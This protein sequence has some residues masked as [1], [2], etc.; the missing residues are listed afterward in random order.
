MY[1]VMI[2]LIAVGLTV[3]GALGAYVAAQKGREPVE[4]LVFGVLLGPLGVLVAGLMPTRDAQS[5]PHAPQPDEEVRD[6]LPTAGM[7]IPE[8]PSEGVDL[9]I[10]W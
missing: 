6:A 8:K 7:R 5:P 10:N 9:D 4:G 3:C 1:W 2:W